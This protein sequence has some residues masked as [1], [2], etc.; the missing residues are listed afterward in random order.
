MSATPEWTQAEIV[1]LMDPV[2]V[3]PV[4]EG[5]YQAAAHGP[6]ERNVVEGG[7]QI[8][9]VIVA[10]SKEVPEQRVTSVS[11]AFSRAARHDLPLDIELDVLRRGR[12]QSTL[13]VRVLQGEKFCSAGTIHMDTGSDDLIRASAA[14]PEVAGPD[15]L[16]DLALEGFDLP[17]RRIRVVDD[18]YDWDRDHV[19]PPELFV[20]ERFEEPGATPALDAALIAHSTTHWTIAAALRPHRGYTEIDAHRTFSSGISMVTVAFHEPA[21]AAQWLLYANQAIHA[22]SGTVQGEGRI[23]DQSGTVVASYTVHAMVRPLLQTGADSG[24][25][26]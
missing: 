23:H 9:A 3:G 16:S 19:G 2:P 21:T 20:W 4:G 11:L 12:T 7:Q 25:M 18:A 1:R 14:L 24:R 5:R 15:E 17:G 10:A 6:S 22:G 13:Q 8:G 26:M